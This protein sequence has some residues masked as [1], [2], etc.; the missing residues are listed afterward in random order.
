MTNI[1]S[2]IADEY[3][4][5]EYIEA[6][7]GFQLRTYKITDA[8]AADWALD[9]IREAKAEYNQ[10]EIIVKEKI[11]Q[12]Q[13]WLEKERE[14][15]DRTVNFFT[16]KLQ[17]YFKTAPKRRT[18][19][20]EVLELPSGTLRR[21]YPAPEFVRDDEK[22][23][24]WLKERGISEYVKIKETPDWANFKKTIRVT[25][26]QVVDENGEIVD[27]VRVVERPPVFEVEV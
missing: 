15:R 1:I 17:E 7:N 8:L 4:K 6:E 11:K 22:L 18:K 23:L 5:E 2:S 10:K 26:E 19:T 27:G 3:M 20:Q 13:E 24:N 16:A 12:L 21:K 9:K 25:G 14:K